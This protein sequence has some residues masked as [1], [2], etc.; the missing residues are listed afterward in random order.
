[1]IARNR[2]QEWKGAW[3]AQ[4]IRQHLGK[5]TVNVSNQNSCGI[6]R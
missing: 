5:E 1:M 3:N 2:I 6:D 4:Q